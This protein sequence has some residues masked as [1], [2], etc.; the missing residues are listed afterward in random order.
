M[1]ALPV[2]SKFLS[3]CLA[4]CCLAAWGPGA[5]GEEADYIKWV[6]FDVTESALADA[7]ALDIETHGTDTPLN[8]IELLAYLAATYGGDFSRYRKAE[9]LELAE[10]LKAG[11]S[12]AAL[13]EGL[14]YFSYYLEAYSAV[15][16]G[17]VG[18]YRTEAPDPADPE[19]TVLETRYGLKAFCPIAR[20]FYYAHYDDFGSGRTYGYDRKHLGHDMFAETGTPIVAVESGVV[21][22]MG[23]NQYGGWRIGIRSF[24]GLRYYYYAHLR[25][26][27]PY[28]CDLA[29]GQTVMAGDV[30]GYMGR[31]GY[32][33]SENVNNIKQSHLHWGMQLIFDPAQKDGTNQIWIDLYAITCLLQRNTSETYRVAETKEFYRKYG[34]SES[35]PPPQNTPVP[36]A[37]QP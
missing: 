22:V 16:G 4:F 34:F 20:G 26:N 33:R 30:I 12:L 5:H 14:E 6:D 10:A 3:F 37:E 35:A 17:F 2:H 11:E 31:T 1:I 23:W 24:D 19:R 36:V 29:E 9:L 27:R 18:E 13:T 25:Q 28:H 7:L 8:W 32:S 21:E 15:L